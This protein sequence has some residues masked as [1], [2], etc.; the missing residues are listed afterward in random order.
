MKVVC[1]PIEVRT[2]VLEYKAKGLKVALVPTM[3][4]LHEG[5]LSLVKKAK[6]EN[7]VVVVS[8][9]VNPIQFGPNEDYN[10]YPRTLEADIEKIKQYSDIVFTPTARD[11]YGEKGTTNIITTETEKSNRLCGR[12]RP[13][14]FNGVLTVVLKLF[15]ICMPD[16]SYFGLKDFQQFVLIKDM[17]EG[18]NLNVKVIGCDIV[19][20]KDD[21]A[22][23]S[24]NAYMDAV[25]RKRALALSESL[26]RIKD[27]FANGETSIASLKAK[28]LEVLQ[29]RVSVQYFEIVDPVNLVTLK[30]ASKGSVV[31]VA[32][33]CDKTRLI[34]NIIL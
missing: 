13:G 3:G 26:N 22:M 27:L 20:E 19:R 8:I 15:N 17:A 5:H 30:E 7:D 25:Q 31:L 10:S 23:S 32:A 34:D 1:D 11:M 21:L 2:L 18:L 28:A 9:F 14:H 6:K 16:V 12:F 24:R 4:N 33:F 29:P